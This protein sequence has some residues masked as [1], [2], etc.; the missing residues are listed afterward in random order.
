MS[1][2]RT[3]QRYAHNKLLK[4]EFSGDRSCYGRCRDISLTGLF[5]VPEEGL[6][7][8]VNGEAG[9][10]QF[11]SG[12]ELHLFACQVVRKLDDGLAIQI[13]D[14]PAKFGM[15]VSHDVFHSLLTSLRVRDKGSSNK[16]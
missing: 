16:G 4:L 14:N 8:V 10:L 9:T 2:N 15:A 11:G 7:D 13:T 12:D 6:P 1:N 5:F 3:H